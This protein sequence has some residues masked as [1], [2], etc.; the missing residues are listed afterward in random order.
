MQWVETWEVEQWKLGGMRPGRV[1]KTVP[2]AHENAHRFHIARLPPA[3]AAELSDYAA[4]R[5]GR[6]SLWPVIEEA[7]RPLCAR[8]LEAAVPGWLSAYYARGLRQGPS[9]PWA[10]VSPSVLCLAWGESSPR[11]PQIP[12]FVLILSTFSSR[13]YLMFFAGLEPMLHS[14]HWSL[15]KR[16]HQ[17]GGGDANRDL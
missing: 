13:V 14:P 7:G 5:P 3:A 4:L 9:G 10:S 2:L 12:Q 16:V 15:C 6:V 17:V 11:P 1:H 8:R